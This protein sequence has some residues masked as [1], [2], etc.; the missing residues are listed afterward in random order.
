M[1]EV[2]EPLRVII[3]EDSEDDVALILRQLRRG[4][5]DPTHLR[6]ETASALT[7]ALDEGGWDIVISDYSLP[8][9]SGLAAVEI[10]ARRGFEI[11]FILVSGTVGEEE[12]VQAMKA[13]AHDYLMKDNLPRL[14]PAVR[15]ELRE[16]QA[17]RERLRAEARLASILD[18]AADA[19]IGVD[20]SQN[21]VF[22]NQGAEEIFGHDT[23]EILGKSLDLL[24]PPSSDEIPAGAQLSVFSASV[25]ASQQQMEVIGR[26]KDGSEFPA[27]VSVSE[28]SQDDGAYFTVILRDITSRK[29]AEVALQEANR[30]AIRQYEQLLQRLIK[31]AQAFGAAQDLAAVYRALASFLEASAPCNGLFIA[32]YDPETELRTCVY[33]GGDVENDVSQLPPMPLNN[34]PQSRAIVSG[35]AVVIDDYQEAVAGL[36]P[37]NLGPDVD[38]RLPQSAIAMPMSVM[39]RIIG[40][41]ELQSVEPAAY[42]Q[43]HVT[44]LRMAASLAAVAIEVSRLLEQIQAQADQVQTVID[45]VPDGVLLID[46]QQRPI[47]VN[48][49]A[50]EYLPLLSTAG[51]GENLTHLGDR[52]LKEILR[53]VD[54]N[55]AR[56]RIEL[57]VNEPQ[58]IFEVAAQPVVHEAE[59]GWVIVLRDVTE[60]RQRQEHLRRQERL[61][62]VGQLAA[63]IAHDFNNV[64]AIIM[65]YSETLTRAP[66]H[67]KRMF[68]LETIREQAGHA[69]SLISQILDF[70]R[71]S[72]MERTR[73]DLLVLVKESVKLLQRTL[74]E[75]ISIELDAEE[76]GSEQYVSEADPTRLRQMLMNLAINARDAMPEGGE[77]RIVLE[78]LRVGPDRPPLPEMRSGAWIAL[79]VHDTGIGITDE[80][81]PHLF[82]PFFTTKE[83]GSGTGLG[84]A[85]VYGI[86]KQHGG[87]IG[88][89]SQ[90]GQ[91]T[92]FTVYLPGLEEEKEES[93]STEEALHASGKTSGTILLVEDDDTTRKAIHETLD[94]LG[95]RVLTATNGREALDTLEHAL[96]AIDLVL[97]DMIMPEMGGLAF[98]ETLKEWQPDARVVIMTGYPLADVGRRALEQGELTWIQKP[99]SMTELAQLV[100]K[101]LAAD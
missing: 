27:E 25:S 72:V 51:E 2:N 68:Y 22:F 33:A 45:T 28:F 60:E 97:T 47:L 5:Y 10:C 87:E 26:R 66:D 99:F 80:A 93:E 76:G 61:A 11:P 71:R 78:G 92:T 37:V 31:L 38:P 91:G 18:T 40:V 8:Q 57:K 90:E 89:E 75:N 86:V 20:E 79:S 63:G 9:F 12:A 62:T 52:P 67:A 30:R 54:E 98:Y 83:P 19:I 23:S 41:F 34:S 7:A 44:A 101:K 1:A 43:E 77:M 55:G 64:M 58:R 73:L 84:L 56:S 42:R 4:G 21:I 14:A 13:G 74:P 65:L 29:E 96:D 3:V 85:Q 6:V 36:S 59:A 24:L 82:E 94:L 88:V 69:A 70:S 46:A 53:P 32:L 81:M 100:R 50:R 95:Y 35:D 15:R 48:P 39:G 17:R 49:V 16:A